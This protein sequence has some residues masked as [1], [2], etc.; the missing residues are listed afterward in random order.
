[1]EVWQGDHHALAFLLED[2]SPPDPIRTGLEFC[3]HVAFVVKLVT[4]ILVTHDLNFDLWPGV[5][6]FI[7][8]RT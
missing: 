1:M 6:K 5:V 3:V 7:L 2:A 4:T 8:G